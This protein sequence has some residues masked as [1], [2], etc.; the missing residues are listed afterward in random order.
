MIARLVGL[1]RLLT[2]RN[3][4][5]RRNTVTPSRKREDVLFGA[6]AFSMHVA[7]R[8]NNSICISLKT[9]M[10]L[11]VPMS[12]RVKI[13]RIAKRQCHIISSHF[14]CCL[15][16]DLICLSSDTSELRKRGKC[17]RVSSGNAKISRDET[18]FNRQKLR[19]ASYFYFMVFLFSHEKKT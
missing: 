18:R 5:A 14:D 11:T 12:A 15:F 13:I 17:A 1:A 6:R 7:S 4:A 10:W 3:I 19:I 8:R 16:T 9:L 2:R